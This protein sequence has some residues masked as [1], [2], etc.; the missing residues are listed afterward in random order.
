VTRAAPPYCEGCAG[1]GV[2]GEDKNGD[3]L[4]CAECD[5][6]GSASWCPYCE[7]VGY[8]LGAAF[9]ATDTEPPKP[10]DCPMGVAF[11][12]RL[13]TATPP[14]TAPD[15]TDSTPAGPEQP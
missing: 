14:R 15:R 12:A 3:A 6:T 11:A 10:C 2:D 8:T 13:R 9:M 1:W 5:G 7:G 4:R